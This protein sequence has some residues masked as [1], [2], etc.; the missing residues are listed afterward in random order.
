MEWGAMQKDHDL[1]IC[2][3]DLGSSREMKNLH[4]V[5]K[6]C[7]LSKLNEREI[8]SRTGFDVT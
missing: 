4:L 7:C 6:F 3:H 2:M 8:G 1:P 5:V